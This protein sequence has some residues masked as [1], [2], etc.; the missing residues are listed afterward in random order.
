MDVEAFQE[1]CSAAVGFAFHRGSDD[2]AS[3][4]H[5]ASAAYHRISGDMDYI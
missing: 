4:G 3:P 5:M 1:L 2:V